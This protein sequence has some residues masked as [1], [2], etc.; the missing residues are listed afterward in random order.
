MYESLVFSR[1]GVDAKERGKAQTEQRCDKLRT[2]L[3]KA[4]LKHDCFLAVHASS[5]IGA[6]NG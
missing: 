1:E 6:E 3:P 5:R 2:S 4:I